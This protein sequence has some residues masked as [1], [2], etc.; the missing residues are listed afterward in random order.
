M[1][2]VSR[3]DGAGGK[4]SL[5]TSVIAADAEAA[6]DV[7][8]YVSEVAGGSGGAAH[9]HTIDEGRAPDA[10][11]ESQQNHVAPPSRRTPQHLGDQ[12]RACVIVSIDGQAIH[13]GQLAQRA[14]F[15]K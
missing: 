10:S 9:D 4:A 8:G 3:L 6:T 2:R 1:G 7:E 12:G 5:Q 11:A 14:S 13:A 15:E